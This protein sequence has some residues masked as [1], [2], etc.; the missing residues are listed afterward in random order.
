MT[1]SDLAN[2]GNLVSSVAVLASVIYL[3]LQVRQ[4]TRNQRSLMDHG[5]S[6]AVSEW[7]RFIA[8]S[9]VSPLMLRGNANDPS[10]TAEERQRYLWCVYP[11]FLHYEDSFYQFREGM[12]GKLQYKSICNQIE[13]SARS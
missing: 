1:L 11:L 6:E 13:D 10:L 5:R 2:I 7:L 3:A 4:T 8:S 12:L 9:D